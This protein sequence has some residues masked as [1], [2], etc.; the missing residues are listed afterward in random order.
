MQCLSTAS[1]NMKEFMLSLVHY[2]FCCFRITR[3]QIAFGTSRPCSTCWHWMEEQVRSLLFKLVAFWLDGDDPYK[4]WNLHDTWYRTSHL[5]QE[6]TNICLLIYTILS[7]FC[8]KP[9]HST[10]GQLLD[11]WCGHFLSI[12]I[13]N[14]L[15]YS[16]QGFI[17]FYLF[18]GK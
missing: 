10:N 16:T 3:R 15:E 14:I 17:S 13:Y 9:N 18:K 5:Q 6:S 7:L 8:I 4:N 2:V 1:V 11:I 12:H